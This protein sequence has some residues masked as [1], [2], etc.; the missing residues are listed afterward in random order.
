MKPRIARVDIDAIDTWTRYR[1]GLCDTCRANCCSMPV[2]VG[3]ADLVRLGLIEPFEAAHEPPRQIAKRLERA[4]V[5]G[6]F[7]PRDTVFTLARHSSGD[8][9]YL[10]Q[11]SRQCTVYAKRPATCRNHPEVGPR[12]GYCPFEPRQD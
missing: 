7:N 4:R 12:P 5:V 3:L 10:D 1:R 2:E 9:L 8:C 6:H 11:G